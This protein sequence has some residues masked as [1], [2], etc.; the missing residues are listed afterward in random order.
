MLLS[1][2][3][4]GL[5]FRGVTGGG[6]ALNCAACGR[7]VS[8]VQWEAAVVAVLPRKTATVVL[9]QHC[10]AGEHVLALHLLQDSCCSKV[11]QQN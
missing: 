8:A 5:G 10:G 3:F 1:A 2:Q 4:L 9:R 7:S 11:F 6:G